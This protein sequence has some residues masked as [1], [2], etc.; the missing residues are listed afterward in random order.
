ML[1]IIRLLSNT[2]KPF[3]HAEHDDH[4]EQ[5]DAHEDAPANP[6]GEVGVHQRSYP[7]ESVTHGGGAEPQAL[8]EAEVNSCAE[9]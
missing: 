8:A 2:L 4:R 6:D 5:A 7:E 3:H 1:I 9:G